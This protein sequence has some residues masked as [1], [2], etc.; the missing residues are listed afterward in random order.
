MLTGET[1]FINEQFIADRVTSD[2]LDVLLASGWRHFGSQFFKYSY[3][4]YE[5]DIRRV[6]PLRVRLNDFSLSK[7]QRRVIRKNDDIEVVIRPTEI[8]REVEE[9]FD[10]H[11]QRFKSGVPESIYDFL[12][13][14]PATIPCKG[15][16]VAVYDDGHLLA[17][18][19]FDV[20]TTANSGIY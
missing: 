3:G 16:E 6:I 20:G 11:K 2:Q 18:S 4:F 10:L 14:E 8:T 17:V 7:S 12:S 9:L 19:Y 15:Q 1:P 13:V 5:L